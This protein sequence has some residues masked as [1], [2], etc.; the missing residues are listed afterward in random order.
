VEGATRHQDPRVSSCDIAFDSVRGAVLDA[1]ALVSPVECAGCGAADRALCGRCR[2]ALVPCPAARVLPDGTTVVSALD[3]GGVA[4]RVLLAL[5]E[6][7]RTDVAGPLGT[8]LA[9]ALANAGFTGRGSAIVPLAVPTS[10]AA[11]RRRGYDPVA[12]LLR[13]AR[14]RGRRELVLVRATGQQK[15]LDVDERASNARGSM[16]ARRSLAGR[17]FVLVDDVTTTGA[18]L[19]EAGRAVRAAGGIVVAAATV[20]H[21]ARR[22]PPGDDRGLNV[23]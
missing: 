1:W 16:R 7:G 12:L 11:F 14:H 21:T 5:K 3:Y 15:R 8:A 13:R 9:A 20:A 18:T 22:L 23:R 4:R 19:V 2:R 17:R 6:Q 10:R